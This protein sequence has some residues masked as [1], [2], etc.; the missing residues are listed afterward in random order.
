MEKDPVDRSLSLQLEDLLESCPK[1]R[2]F[3]ELQAEAQ[4]LATGKLNLVVVGHFKRGKSSILN[5]LIGRPVLPMG[6]VPVT[7]LVTLIR[8]GP[9][10]SAH[11][12]FLDGRKENISL[13]Q[14]QEFVSEKANPEN[15]L[16]VERV[17]I[18]L[19]D[20][21]LPANVVLADTPGSGSVFQH[22]TE[23]LKQWL[24]HIDAA[25]FVISAEP[26]VGQADLE[27]L[28]EVRSRAGETKIV[29]NKVD[30]LEGTELQE[31]IDYARGAVRTEI[32]DGDDLQL[33]SA[34]R[35]LEGRDHESGID[36]LRTWIED[37]SALRADS[38][39]E[40]AVARRLTRILSQETALLQIESAATKKNA[41]ELERA[42]EILEQIRVEMDSRFMDAV[43]LH[44]A[45]RKA[46]L[47]AYD[48]AAA[49]QGPNLETAL[50]KRLQD[51][52]SQ[53]AEKKLGGLR[54]LPELEKER[55]TSALQILQPFQDQQESAL[56]EGFS[57][58]SERVLGHIN[59]LVDDAFI[60]AGEALGLEI[61]RFDL[62]EGFRMESRLIYRLGLPKVNLDFFSDW[63]LMLL[64][65]P[66]AR[67]A[68]LRRQLRFLKDSIGRQL[69]LIRADLAERLNESGISFEANLRRRVLE[70]GEHLLNALES[71]RDLL[72]SGKGDAEN[73]VQE[74]SRINARVQRVLDTCLY[75]SAH[76]QVHLN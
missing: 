41:D 27:L 58:L 57:A 75:V 19:P 52:S 8:N 18:E 50:R 56:I 14:I 71:G 49:Q 34:L 28:Q 46:L 26:P 38:I 61:N 39:L 47:E 17:D 20:L 72:Q 24:G 21:N 70:A 13:S 3:N 65:P 22:N 51:F 73:R 66:L 76:R 62:R 33:C 1:L 35:S 4:R 74:L 29:L 55:D 43:A 42:F 59:H 31:A 2:H 7:A 5:A 23:V 25:I 54:F 6:V 67:A 64:P 69:G 48:Q 32:D 9:E 44:R 16:G 37:L 11:V 60:R 15:R 53:A 45:G 40:K 30:R 63:V 10:E 36:E 12:H 68:L